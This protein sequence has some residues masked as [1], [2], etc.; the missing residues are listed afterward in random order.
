MSNNP[1]TP[2]KPTEPKFDGFYG[3]DLAR[4]AVRGPALGLITVSSIWICLIVMGMG[5]SAYLLLSGMAARMPQPSSIGITKETQITIR[6]IWS[7]VILLSNI[8]ILTAA[9]KMQSLRSYG[10]CK[11]GAI[12]AIIP[13]TGP[14]YLLGIPFGIWALV[15]LSK[16]GIPESFSS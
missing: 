6:L 1:F 7:S 16:P 10:F 12:L 13:C 14:C 5:F 9:L 15:A 2:P 3:A 4:D 11:F 8:V